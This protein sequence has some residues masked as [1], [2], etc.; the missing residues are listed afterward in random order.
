MLKP[1]L[2]YPG[3]KW[4]LRVPILARLA[5]YDGWTQFRE[6]FVGGGAISIAMIIAHPQ[7][8]VWIND[9][10]MS[11]YCMWK[12]LRDHPDLLRQRVRDFVPSRE[13]YA[14]ICAYLR[15]DPIAACDHDRAHLALCKLAAHCL[16]FS[17]IGVVAAPRRLIG[18]KWNPD[19]LC[20]KIARLQLYI[21]HIRITTGDYYRLIADQ[22]VS[23][24]LY[25]DPPYLGAGPT[26]Y[27]HFFARYRDHVEL[28]QRLRCTP[29]QWVLS[30][31]DCPQIRCLYQDWADIDCLPINYS[32]RKAR[33]STTE[34][35]ISSKLPTRTGG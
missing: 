32:T 27:S 24:L 35:L 22:S 25:L 23:C 6:P 29:H 11:I 20:E 21:Q 12:T 16:A 3:G 28:A 8:D 13:A 7:R 34:L 31:D 19:H 33:A 14:Q 9:L 18:E 15:S 4:Q 10:D 1:I 17:G 26:L 2:R 5:Q 30:Y